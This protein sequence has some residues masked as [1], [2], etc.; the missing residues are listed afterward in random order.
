MQIT[1][2]LVSHLAK[3]A[4]LHLTE[5]ELESQTKD[6]QNILG[7]IEQLQALDLET[8]E[9]TSQVNGLENVMQEDLVELCPIE[10]ELLAQSPQP[11]ENDM[12][13]ISRVVK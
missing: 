3:L 4:R 2:D 9:E 13:C 6:I 1:K 5:D 12:I 8:V 7:L 10:K 11:V